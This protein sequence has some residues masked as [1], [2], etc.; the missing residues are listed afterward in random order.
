M[1]NKNIA[2]DVD[3]T[4]YV[5]GHLND[6]V[7]AF[8]TMA[9]GKGYTLMLWSARGKGHAQAIAD[10]FGVGLNTLR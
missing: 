8:C 6:K 7:V 3:G 5:N 2:I 1:N 10:Q 9:K 4:L